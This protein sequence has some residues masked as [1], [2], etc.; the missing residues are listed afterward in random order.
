MNYLTFSSFNK[1]NDQ[2][3]Q[4]NGFYIYH[5]WKFQIATSTETWMSFFAES[6]QAE[7][8]DT[9][10][11]IS[12][13]GCTTKIFLNPGHLLCK[14]IR[15]PKMQSPPC[16]VLIFLFGAYLKKLSQPEDWKYFIQTKY[17][18]SLCFQKNL[19]TNLFLVINLT[20]R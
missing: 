13:S 5:C 14:F 1:R 4:I 6:F 8:M 9:R 15:M 20:I 3:V 12:I 10:T 18:S 11:I 17:G 16:T 7:D 2:I 19:A